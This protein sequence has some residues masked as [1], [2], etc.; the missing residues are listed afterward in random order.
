V[1][2][3][4][5][6]D[7]L[8]L[9]GRAADDPAARTCALHSRHCPQA[10]SPRHRRLRDPQGQPGQA[11]PRAD[12]RQAVGDYSAGLDHPPANVSRRDAHVHIAGT[13]RPRLEVRYVLKVLHFTL[14]GDHVRVTLY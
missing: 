7:Q 6:S 1:I 8:M 2:L 13:W 14:V 10:A 9:P 12:C 3:Y 5:I 11:R 4:L